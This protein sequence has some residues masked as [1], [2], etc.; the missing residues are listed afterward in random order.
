MPEPLPPKSS[1]EK[2]GWRLMLTGFFIVLLAGAAY[3]AAPR[4]GN[5]A[6]MTAGYYLMA[7]GLVA[8]VAGRVL[9][10]RGRR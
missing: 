3:F 9:R 1:R 8:Y 5:P 2:S 7:A 6:F 10:W 4:L